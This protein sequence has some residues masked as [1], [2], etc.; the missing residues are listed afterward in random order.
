[1]TPEQEREA[2]EAWALGPN[3]PLLPIEKY[4]NGEYKET[5]TADA[6]E[7]W[8]AARASL[9][10]PASVPAGWKLVPVEPTLAML[11]ALRADTTPYLPDRYRAMLAAA[12]QAPQPAQADMA[13]E[14]AAAVRELAEQSG[15]S[16]AQVLRAAVRLYQAEQK[17]LVTVE[18]KE[19]IGPLAAPQPEAQPCSLQELI[20]L[21][22]ICPEL[23]IGNYGLDD[24]EKLNDWAVE[25]AQEI[26]RLA[27]PSAQAPQPEAQPKW[28]PIETAP[29]DGS[30]Q[31][32]WWG[33]S[34]AFAKWLDNSKCKYPWAGWQTPS[35]TPRPSGEP[36][37]W[38]PLPAAPS[39]QAVPQQA[40]TVTLVGVK[41]DGTEHVLGTATMPPKMRAKELV[42][43][44]FGSID[45]ETGDDG[46]MA[47][48]VCEQLIEWMQETSLVVTLT[49]Q[50]EQGGTK[51]YTRP[52]EPLTQ[53]KLI[54]LW[55]DKSDGPSNAEI[56]S[57][58]RAIERAHGIGITKDT[59]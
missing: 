10:Q 7:T 52:L 15:M 43:E 27:A 14:Y 22:S 11:D 40:D 31:V 23:N 28:Q 18:H 8:Q 50:A 21:A 6:W 29:K 30:L 54:A 20:R 13:P 49:N 35:L 46:A 25:V 39:A 16:E 12:P 38:M 59:K 48:W 56:V 33:G 36:T 17:G 2:F 51:L 53:T 26:D 1:M 41:A 58:A 55:A 42:R 47:L 5:A 24:V 37:H 34:V 3:A 44:M 32:L 57:F 4:M 45:E 19:Q 9:A